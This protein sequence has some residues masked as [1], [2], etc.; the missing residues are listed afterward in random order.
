MGNAYD[1]GA[2]WDANYDHPG[3]FE[4]SGGTKSL[5]TV[6]TFQA[7]QEEVDRI[8]TS[9]V[10]E[11]EL[12]TAKD[13]ALNSLVFAYDTRAKTL[14]RMLTY[15]YYG[16]P[17]DFIEQY[18][19]ALE[20]VTRA[21]VLRVAKEHLN[22][23]A[24]TTV[25]VGNPDDFGR[26]L[27]TLGAPVHM[28]D[29]TIPQETPEAAKGD[30]ASLE[31]GK[32]LLARAQQAVGGAGPLAA[33]KDY[34]RSYDLQVEPSAGGMLMKETDRWIAPN[35][36][37][38][39]TALP[40]ISVFCDGK[41]G[42]F[43]ASQGSGPLAGAQLKQVQGDLFRLY[44]RLLL[45]D[46][47]AGRTVNAL[48]DNTVEISDTGGAIARLELN[49]ETGLPQRL[50]YEVARAS[51]PPIPAEEVWADFQE[52]AGVKVPQK[53]TIAQGGRKFA[54]VKLTGCKVNSGIQLQELQKRP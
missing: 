13:T 11:E 27:D 10:T 43:A 12:K 25:A 53:I 23:A 45:S 35:Y 9:E 28:I 33:V 50:L 31:K 32:R 54:E 47:I 37:R 42:W 3:W 51:G 20:A 40:K 15:E 52:I 21:D 30:A 1:I 41:A 44:F 7:I 46:R 38:Q 36:F 48:D 5:S 39:D 26:P 2:G 14:A 49:A 18:Q 6:E 29:L 8:R 17:P 4:I 19:K 34:I 16:Y 24:F 22:P